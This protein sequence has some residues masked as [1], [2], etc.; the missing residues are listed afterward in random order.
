M[1]LAGLPIRANTLNELAALTRLFRLLVDCNH[2]RG[3]GVAVA[4]QC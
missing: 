1:M 3:E 2:P 4:A